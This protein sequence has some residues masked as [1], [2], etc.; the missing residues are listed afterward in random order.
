MTGSKESVFVVGGGIV[1]AAC[2]SACA[3]AGFEVTLFD[4]RP[5]GS[6]SS[7]AGMG[8]VVVM[9]DSEAQMRLT[10]LGREL[11]DGFVRE[12]E[13]DARIETDRTGT[14]WVAEDA[15]DMAAVHSKHAYYAEHGVAS[16]VL[17][18]AALREAEAQLRAGLPG[19]LRV[20][21]DFVVYAP[22]V[23][24]LLVQD[25]LAN[26]ARV[27]SCAV[28]QIEDL[29]GRGRIHRNGGGGADALE[30]DWVINAAGQA[31]L[32][33][34][35]PEGFDTSLLR[36]RKGQLAITDRYPGYARHQ[37]VELGY[38]KS[39]HGHAASSV[40][41]NLQPRRTGQMLLGSSREFDNEDPRVDAELMHRMVERATSFL[42]GIGS[43]RVVR[44]W[45]GFRSA[46]PDHL[47]MV[48]PSARGSRVLFACGHEGLGITT[49]L[50]TARLLVDFLGDGSASD[51]VE[52][53]SEAGDEALP[54]GPY[55]PSR[56]AN[57][58][59]APNGAEGE[60]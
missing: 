29:E 12:H 60:E 5:P 22:A 52:G 14:L 18:E 2:A 47:P 53:G 8:H 31:A 10:R 41:F 23:V 4:G 17:D 50:S 20:P 56:F 57:A 3:R 32:Q 7:A 25:A 43:L 45:A 30:A 49:S 51:G 44:T 13:G 42:P 19:A 15:E 27:E 6:A 21:G 38:L 59:D 1:G 55:L 35:C 16:E 34:F 33:L 48:G 36:Q 26:G 24:D 58:V 54:I 37:L 9:D 40:A 46:T 11:W 39:A 28:R